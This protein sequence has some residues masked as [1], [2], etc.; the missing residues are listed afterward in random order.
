MTIGLSILVH[1]GKIALKQTFHPATLHNAQI[2]KVI[3]S[4]TELDDAFA[5]ALEDLKFT[6][7]T[8]LFDGSS[9]K[10]SALGL[11]T[12]FRYHIWTL[13]DVFMRT[14]KQCTGL[15]SINE[16]NFGFSGQN[17]IIVKALDEIYQY[18][19]AFLEASDVLSLTPSELLAHDV[20]E[21]VNCSPLKIQAANII[22]QKAADKF[23]Y[24][25]VTYLND[26]VAVEPTVKRLYDCLSESFTSHC[27]H[28]IREL[29][30]ENQTDPYQLGNL[31]PIRLKLELTKKSIIPAEIDIVSLAS[32][33]EL[34]AELNSASASSSEPINEEHA[35]EI[36]VVPVNMYTQGTGNFL[37]IQI[38]GDT[39][40]MAA[41]IIELTEIQ[42]ATN[43]PVPELTMY[44]MLYSQ[45]KEFIDQSNAHAGSLTPFIWKSA[46]ISRSQSGDSVLSNRSLSRV[47]MTPS[48]ESTSSRSATPSG[49][50]QDRLIR[51]HS[52]SGSYARATSA[53]LFKPAT[54]SS[55]LGDNASAITSVPLAAATAISDLSPIALPAAYDFKQR[56]ELAASPISPAS[57][58][59]MEQR[60]AESKFY[61]RLE[62]F[63]RADTAKNQDNEDE[64]A[65][66]INTLAQWESNSHI[67]CDNF[68]SRSPTPEFP[69][70]PTTSCETSQL[71]LVET[72]GGERSF[73]EIGMPTLFAPSQELHHAKIDLPHLAI[74]AN[75]AKILIDA[76]MTLPV[77]HPVAHCSTTKGPK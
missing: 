16:W 73:V 50:K 30:T 1:G 4:I 77:I 53:V 61:E 39:S 31:Q 69:K 9:I 8:A 41:K 10:S 11:R 55:S 15:I 38:D 35:H 44:H 67:D 3:K 7:P 19:N 24:F 63:Y 76:T 49:V 29:L 59:L 6:L 23:N 43:Q 12:L 34:K 57:N 56:I 47:S 33:S 51:T 72:C 45:F 65:E 52:V 75:A 58:S 42:E 26:S 36:P 18:Y 21:S 48:S 22:L 68:L 66:L 64:D 62:D 37:I 28:V 74:S 32:D 2:T 20:L 17:V 13:H 54:S 14:Q 70:A 71:L 25:A 46:S 40:S 60:Q 5:G 27:L